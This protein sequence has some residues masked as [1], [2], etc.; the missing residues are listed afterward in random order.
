MANIKT[1]ISLPDEL[2][3]LVEQMARERNISRS[4]LFVLAMQEY[5]ERHRNR[6]IKEQINQAYEV[7]PDEEEQ[8]LLG[9][10][11]RSQR[12]LVEGEWK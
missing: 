1:A 10:M 7:G 3:G 9:K 12:R 2:Y 8:E 5:I 6:Q 11:R 4:H